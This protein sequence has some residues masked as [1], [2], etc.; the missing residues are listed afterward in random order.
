MDEEGK[1]HEIARYVTSQPDYSN[2]GCSRARRQSTQGIVLSVKA[3]PTRQNVKSK[4]VIVSSAKR[5]IGKEKKGN[6]GLNNRK[7]QILTQETSNR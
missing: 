7:G 5:G 1:G 4:K 3:R 2:Q 6:R